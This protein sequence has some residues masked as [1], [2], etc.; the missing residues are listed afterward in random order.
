MKS[1][2]EGSEAGSVALSFS[3]MPSALR[4]ETANVLLRFRQSAYTT[5]DSLQVSF[6]FF[7]IVISFLF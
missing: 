3:L 4:K 7:L 1:T 5:I 6:F 2:W